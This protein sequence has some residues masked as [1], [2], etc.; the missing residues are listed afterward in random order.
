MTE[1][2]NEYNNKRDFNKTLEPKGATATEGD[3]LRFV[4]QHHIAR[5]DHYDF[6]LEWRGTMLS[7]AIPK[8]P[9]YD[10]SEKRLSIKVEDHP[11]DY[12]NFEG[13]IPKGEYGGGVV[14]IWDEGYWEPQGSIAEGLAKGV[15]KFTL[16]GSRLKGKWS[17]VQIKA[18]EGDDK[19]NWLLVKEKDEYARL[20]DGIAE[21]NTSIRTSR[22][23]KEIEEG[24]DKTAVKNPFTQM[25]VQLAK[26]STHIPNSEDWL[27]ELKYDGYRIIAYIEGVNVKLVS[28][29][30]KDYTKHFQEV[31]NSLISLAGGR[32]MVLDGE[33]TVTDELGKTNFQS[34]Q[35]YMKNPKGKSL[36]YYVF[37][38]IAL[39]GEDLREQKLI[40]RKQKLEAIMQNS[41]PHLY[42]SRHIAG[43]GKDCFN[44]ACKL[45]MEGIIGKR[46]GSK[47]RGIRNDD[48]IKIKCDNRQEFVIGG[49]TLTDK[50]NSGVSALLLGFYQGEELIYIG[51]AGTGMSETIIQELE[52]KFVKLK[53]DKSP[54]MNTPKK[55]TNE[56]IIWLQ[57][58]LVAEIKYAEITDDSKLRQASYKGLRE[59]KDPKS[60]VFETAINEIEAQADKEQKIPIKDKK[61]YIEGI[62]ISNPDKVLY[63]NP[64][65]T[66]L[67]VVEYYSRVSERMLPYVRRR[68]LSVVRC[69]KGVKESCFY[70]KHP[71]ANGKGIISIP[72]NNSKDKDDEY[73][74][75]DNSLGLIHE[76]Q[77]GTIE[78]HTWGS[79]VDN[80]DMPDMMVFD[81]DPDEGMHLDKV[82]QGVR[83]LKD[84]LSELQL[85]CY[86]KTSGGKGYHVVVPFVPCCNWELF[87]DFAK[88][89][90]QVMEQKWPDK[91]TSNVR[92]VN[93]A[94]KIYIDWVRNG[95][96]A[97][98]IA[99]YSLRAREGAKV[100]MPIT[101]E[102]LDKIA[103]D[104]IT[105]DEAFK[106]IAQSDPWHDF[107]NNDQQ[108]SNK[109]K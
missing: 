36:I 101:W 71:M 8:G 93:R 22:T 4:V 69:P 78:F 40:D 60:V 27:Y 106:R 11:I 53:L 45:N 31:V 34:L 55:R 77:M 24:L 19:D 88:N 94:N 82:R 61:D 43:K 108:L 25:E 44:A 65:V 14:M 87:H 79:Q 67:D 56:N 29:N 72:I 52:K 63:N 102:E 99:P 100:S 3:S 70:K 15:L 37:D 103:P 92:K 98:S 16:Y 66:K 109:I 1:V 2:L 30:G 10:P 86:L 5:R 83:D 80:L 57:P 84:V 13:T 59:D 73:F 89:I 46:S 62:K 26:L 35:S 17:I 107:Y 50:K 68:V 6:R 74:Y 28:R 48:W 7:W 18:K 20:E 9:S 38:L 85:E 23:M 33:M 21:F 12:R 104:G 54:F 96:G 41:P 91:Y 42:Y 97:T 75:I 51:R 32:T 90:A 64:K 105:M 76:A 49:Y 47:Y 81:L 39:D 58:Q 95:R